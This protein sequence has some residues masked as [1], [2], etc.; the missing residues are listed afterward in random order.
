VGERKARKSR[1]PVSGGGRFD[2]A[3]LRIQQGP[4]PCRLVLA[5]RVYGF[6]S[7]QPSLDPETVADEVQAPGAL[8]I[9]KARLCGGELRNGEGRQAVGG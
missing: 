6:V 4:R 5:A 9:T 1:L 8:R 3:V 2:L 7:L